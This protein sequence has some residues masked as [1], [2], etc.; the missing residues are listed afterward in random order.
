VRAEQPRLGALFIVRFGGMRSMFKA[1]RWAE[2]AQRSCTSVWWNV[3][4]LL[5]LPAVWLAWCVPR[6]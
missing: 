4:V 6:S 2:E 5:A 1:S 3:W